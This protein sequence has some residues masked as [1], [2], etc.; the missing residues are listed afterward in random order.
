MRKL[1]VVAVI[2][3]LSV[4]YY[5]CQKDETNNPVPRMDEKA[6]ITHPSNIEDMN[7]YLKGFLDKML[8]SKSE[9]FL[10]I[11]EAEWHLTNLENYEYANANVEYNDIRFDTIYSDI[12]ITSGEITLADLNVAYATIKDK[13]CSLY[14][15]LE[16]DNKNFRYISSNITEEGNIV[17]STIMT[18]NNSSKWYYFQDDDFCDLYFDDNTSYPANGFAVT[19]LERLINLIVGKPTDPSTGRLYY[20][21]NDTTIFHYNDYPDPTSP[22]GSRLYNSTGY[23]ITSIPKE[24]MCYYLD[25][26]IDLS[27]IKDP[28]ELR[29]FVECKVDF[30]N[31]YPENVETSSASC[32][33][34]HQLTAYYGLPV[35]INNP[36]ILNER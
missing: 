35:M 17:T 24:D 31:A 14:N 34:N 2:L 30:L 36:P 16:L 32:V 7:A 3:T 8:G 23:Y 27:R 21:V 10:S 29:Y 20:V 18:Y 4:V 28:F 19:E 6:F 11:A 26:Y 33:G 12:T 9:G 22:S 25:S 5:S 13:I 1:F 15:S